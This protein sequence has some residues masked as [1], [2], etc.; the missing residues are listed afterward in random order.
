M[1]LINIKKIKESQFE[2][3]TTPSASDGGGA[4]IGSGGATQAPQFN[5]VG[6][7]GM[8]QLAQLQQKPVQAFVVSSEMT[9]AQALER[10]RINNATI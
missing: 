1:G 9:S 7:N 5:V 4:D 8:N 2:G 3:G 6:N 10:N